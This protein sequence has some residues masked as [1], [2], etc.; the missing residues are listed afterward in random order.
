MAEDFLKMNPYTRFVRAKYEIRGQQVFVRPSGKD[1]SSMIHSLLET[2]A[3]M[4][5]PGGTKGFQSGD[6]VQII[7]L[8]CTEGSDSFCQLFKS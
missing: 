3:L 1:Q 4:I 7:P 5:L 8:D 6:V 2:N